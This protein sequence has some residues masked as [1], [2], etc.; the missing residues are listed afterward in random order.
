MA[1]R[2]PYETLAG[3]LS[4]STT[5]QQLL[6]NLRLAEEDAKA[7]SSMCKA[8]NATSQSAAWATFATK[9]HKVQLIV[10][11]LAKSK[12]RTSIGFTNG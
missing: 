4:S 2:L 8:R 12:A 3:N 5:Y 11:D 7:L 10:T 1:P 9:F 6:E